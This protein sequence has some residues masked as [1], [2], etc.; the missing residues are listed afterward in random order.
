[1]VKSRTQAHNKAQAFLSQVKGRGNNFQCVLARNRICAL[2]A[3]KE[4]YI[5][6]PPLRWT[7]EESD[8]QLP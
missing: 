3:P 1:M 6:I 8:R 4:V 2:W 7:P 5:G